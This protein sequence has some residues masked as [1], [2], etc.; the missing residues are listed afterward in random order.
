M[1]VVGAVTG[2]KELTKIGGVLGVVG[3]V[4]SLV[5]GGLSA[6]VGAAAG[7]AAM[8]EAVSNAAI[9]AYDDVAINAAN[10]AVMQ[11]AI[12]EGVTNAAMDTVASQGAGVVGSGQLQPITPTPVSQGA[13]AS[14]AAPDATTAARPDALSVTGA[15]DKAASLGAKATQGAAEVNPYTMDSTIVKTAAS[16]PPNASLPNQKSGSFFG[17]ILGW[18]EKNQTMATGIGKF[19]LGA[20]QGLQSGDQFE[21]KVQLERE[22]TARA[23]TVA[24][25]APTGGIINSALRTA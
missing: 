15:G 12:G 3:G 21:T 9:D 20:L 8:S 10:D 25:F 5:A 22:R 2:S 19:G 11:S 24:N 14:V 18:A 6:G 4:G 17:D 13:V 16:V 23:N 1:T 7:D